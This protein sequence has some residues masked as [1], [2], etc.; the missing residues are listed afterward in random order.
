MQP[1]SDELC[2][3]IVDVEFWIDLGKLNYLR[4]RQRSGVFDERNKFACPQAQRRRGRC[5][6]SVGRADG[7]HVKAEKSIQ[8]RALANEFLPNLLF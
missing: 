4:I 1:D 3:A 2:C 8:R 5:S 7:V 6:R